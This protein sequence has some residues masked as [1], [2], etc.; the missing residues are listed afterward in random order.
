MRSTSSSFWSFSDKEK[1]RRKD[2][3]LCKIATSFDILDEY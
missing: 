2:M 1:N 3:Q